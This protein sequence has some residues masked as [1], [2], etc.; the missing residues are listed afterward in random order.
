MRIRSGFSE[1]G[2][3]ATTHNS[4]SLEVRLE[5]GD[6]V[7][8]A[9]LDVPLPCERDL[10]YLRGLH[11][12]H[13][14][15]E[16]VTYDPRT[17]ELAG[18]VPTEGTAHRL[19]AIF[20]TFSREVTA[21]VRKT[22]PRYARDIEPDRVSFMPMEEATRPWW[23]TGRNDLLHI[24]VSTHRPLRG[25]RLLRVYVNIN[26]CEPRVWTTSHNFAELMT[27]YGPGFLQKLTLPPGWFQEVGR[28]IRKLFSVSSAITSDYDVL[29]FGFHNFLKACTHLQECAPR[30]RWVFP[31]MSAWVAMTDGV[32]H[33]VLRGQFAL[34]HSFIVPVHALADFESSPCATWVRNGLMEGPI[35]KSAA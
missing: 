6:L 21:W 10:H 9:P 14:P 17:R 28:T 25:H 34:E 35:L 4:V 16:N 19:R 31:P 20:S 26:P 15:A 1:S 2:T 29:M 24:D 33:A 3:L 18:I 23:A 12:P 5:R 7:P 30:H 13:S 27:R 11:L 22:L 8:R 32:A